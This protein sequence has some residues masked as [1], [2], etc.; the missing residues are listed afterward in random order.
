MDVL[1]YILVGIT[2]ACF[3]SFANVL[4]YRLPN[5]MS[6]VSPD[7]HCVSCNHPISWYDNLPIISYIILRGRCRYCKAKFSPRYM[8]VELLTAILFC[9][10]LMW[11]GINYYTIIVCLALVTML[12]IFFID[13]EHQIIPDSLVIALLVCGI[14]SMFF[15]NVVWWERLVGFA[16]C[17]LILFLIGLLTSKIAKKDALGFGDVKLV[18]V[19]GL[20]VGYKAGLLAIFMASVF[21]GIYLLFIKIVKKQSIDK[22]F[23]F[24]P[25]LTLAFA[26]CMFFGD[27]IVKWYFG[28]FA[29]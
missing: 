16:G 21:A 24:A 14:A 18:A 20:L 12:A 26:I 10:A 8:I 2:G 6:I 23:G 15:S 13:W 22:P 19:C 4:I 27:I 3:G 29:I 25:F 28:L 9:L 17:G 11:F 5:N 7:S 1:I